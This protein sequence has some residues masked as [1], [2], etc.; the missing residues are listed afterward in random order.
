MFAVLV[1]VATAG[2]T[3][4]IAKV[5][6][7]R[8]VPIESKSQLSSF[9]ESAF[10]L[11]VL[12]SIVVWLGLAPFVAGFGHVV[13]FVEG[14]IGL[15]VSTIINFFVIVILVDEDLFLIPEQEDT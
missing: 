3:Y 11:S 10:Q 5:L 12:P 1:W 14:V 13:F 9:T 4:A 8:T 2:W 7:K 6:L 15:V